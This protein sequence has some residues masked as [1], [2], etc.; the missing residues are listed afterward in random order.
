MRDRT[1]E[2][3]AER[4]REELELSRLVPPRG[5]ALFEEVVYDREGQLV[6]GSLMDY[7]MP[8]AQQ[9]SDIDVCFHE[10]LDPNNELGVKGI[11]EGGAC[12]APAAIANAVLDALRP[13]GVATLDMPLTSE[14]VWNA[15]RAGAEGS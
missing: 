9:L 8:R 4:R 5:E 6:T 14:K 3:P 7:S 10:V 12:A 15:I 1:L 13:F 11:G 2:E